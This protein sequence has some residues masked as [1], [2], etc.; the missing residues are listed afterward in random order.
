MRRITTG[1]QNITPELNRAFL[2]SL[3]RRRR[4]VPEQCGYRSHK[5]AQI[6]IPFRT[7]GRTEGVVLYQTKRECA[8]MRLRG[9]SSRQRNNAPSPR[10]CATD[11]DVVA[12]FSCAAWI[13][14]EEGKRPGVDR[15]KFHPSFSSLYICRRKCINLPHCHL[16]REG[17]D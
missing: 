15:H 16:G 3:R 12:Q 17:P 9:R 4:R 8:M 11:D 5:K 10:N 6:N 13:M 7:D 14:V 2:P 1:R